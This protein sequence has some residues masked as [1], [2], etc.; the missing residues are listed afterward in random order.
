MI[1]KGL[2]YFV[3]KKGNSSY[4]QPRTRPLKYG[5]ICPYGSPVQ[6]EEH[7]KAH[8]GRSRRS[9]RLCDGVSAAASDSAARS[10]SGPG[11][12]AARAS[13]RAASARSGA[14]G[15]RGRAGCH[16]R[17]RGRA[18]CYARACSI[19]AAASSPPPSP[20]SSAAASATAAP[21]PPRPPPRQILKQGRLADNSWNAD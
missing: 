2:V 14:A 12:R 19:A 3:A 17:A 6:E 8:N 7:E 13:G 5:K 10:G 4:I 15:A 11:S 21:S 9:G 16:A 20:P 18:G 1:F